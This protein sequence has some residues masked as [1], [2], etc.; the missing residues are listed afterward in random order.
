ML[1]TSETVLKTALIAS[2]DMQDWLNYFSRMILKRGRVLRTGNVKI[3]QLNLVCSN[4]FSSRCLWEGLL[5]AE[6][7]KVS[8]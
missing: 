7:G 5:A 2:A 3:L 6:G 1:K 8:N 4:Y